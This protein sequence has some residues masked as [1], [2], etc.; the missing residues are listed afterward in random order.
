MMSAQQ[1]GF[2][3][4]ADCGARKKARPGLFHTARMVQATF[5]WRLAS[6]LGCRPYNR[7]SGSLLVTVMGVPPV[8]GVAVKV[9]CSKEKDGAACFHQG[10]GFCESFKLPKHVSLTSAC[11]LAY[12]GV[13]HSGRRAGSGLPGSGAPSLSTGQVGRV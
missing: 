1:V 3:S 5:R 8:D 12:R 9:Y 10:E 11:M 4:S 7:T 2:V 6:V 13:R